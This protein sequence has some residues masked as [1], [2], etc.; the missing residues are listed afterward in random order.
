MRKEVDF[1]QILRP[2]VHLNLR[3]GE[4]CSIACSAHVTHPCEKCGRVATISAERYFVLAGRYDQYRFYVD[5]YGLDRVRFPY[6]WE[7]DFL[8]GQRDAIVL[9]YGTWY[10][11]KD[12]HYITDFCRA[13]GIKMLDVE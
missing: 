6:L 7:E 13:R 5:K 11:R 12:C 2:T 4:P 10:D 9:R 3:D 8:P 1:S